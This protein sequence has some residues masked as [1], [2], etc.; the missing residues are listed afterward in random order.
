MISL[1]MTEQRRSYV[2]SCCFIDAVKTSVG[3]HL[4]TGRQEDVWFLKRLL[5]AH[6]DGEVQLFTSTMT[7]AECSHV[8]EQPITDKVKSEFSRL[9][10]SGQYV[11]LVQATP[12]IAQDARD[13]RWNHD[14][15]LSGLDTIHVASAIAMRCEEFL[16][17]N[18]KLTR[19]EAQASK[20][21]R[22]G[23]YGKRAKDTACLP[24]KYRQLR[25]DDEQ[26]S[27]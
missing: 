7:I 24:A 17:S 26:T 3:L 2:D 1:S 12:F 19:I 8:G 4:E 23:L 18:G 11:R 5:E 6:R 10:A 9:L 27:S 16:S 15:L 14:I 21:A 25:L 20:I 13:L 22:L